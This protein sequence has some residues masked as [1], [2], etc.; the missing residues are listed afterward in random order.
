NMSRL[1]YNATT[2]ELFTGV[3]LK[4]VDDPSTLSQVNLNITVTAYGIQADGLSI[5]AD[6]RISLLWREYG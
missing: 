2:P 4:N 3:T 5:C 1:A 6:L